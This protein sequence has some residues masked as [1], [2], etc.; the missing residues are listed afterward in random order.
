[1]RCDAC[2]G[3]TSGRRYDKGWFIVQR[4]EGYSSAVSGGLVFGSDS[5]DATTW[6]VC[7][8]RCLA[9]LVELSQAEVTA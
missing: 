2:G 9:V 5:L 1:M 4:V 7:S 3:F 6:A 8:V